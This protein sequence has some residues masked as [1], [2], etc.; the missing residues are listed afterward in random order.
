MERKETDIKIPLIGKIAYGMGDVGCTF[1]WAFVGSFLMIFYTD[2]FGISMSAVAAL[3]LVSRVWDAVNDPM[4]GSLSDRTRTKWGTYRPWL[5]IA[6]PITAVILIVTFWAHPDWS[7]TSKVIYMVITY[8]LLV[9]GYTAVNIP[10][11]TLCGA[12]TQNFEER[13][14][15]TTFR[16]TF[17][18][19]ATAILNV[20]TV[21]LIDRL[22]QGSSTQGY[23][24]VAIVYGCIFAAC[25]F[26]CFAKT[27]EVVQVEKTEKI[28]LKMQLKSV[29][30]NKPFL[31]VLIGQCLMGFTFYA[32]NSDILY[33][34]TYVEGN[35][36]LFS[37]YS[38]VLLIPGI[39][40]A[41]SYPLVFKFTHNKGWASA[42]F[43]IGT[44][45]S[46]IA[47]YWFSMSDNP[48]AFCVIAGISWFF[49]CGHNS[50]IYAMIPDCVEYGELK[51]GVRNDGFLYSL[52]SL[53]NKIGMALGSSLVA[54]VLGAAGYVANQ[55]QNETVLTVMK[56][57]FSVIPG[58][59]WLLMALAYLFYRLDKRKY[60]QILIELK[61]KKSG[62]ES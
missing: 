29:V 62:A 27:K 39:F 46:I 60:A 20:I 21:P 56:L 18:M 35:V 55:Q 36:K 40:G 10:Y 8:G 53:S 2:V 52:S 38:A 24:L 30:H 41:A 42:F 43:A 48:V 31:L 12:M 23:L 34:F 61:N 16:S 47:F 15:I 17:A 37:I 19:A 9:T 7:A 28:N 3:M 33:Y 45:V 14:K 58:A 5:L 1:S 32:R 59:V 57:F 50:G 4:I 26:F 6:A 22:G 25:H 13:A 11:G 54:S 49:L 51:T 44:G